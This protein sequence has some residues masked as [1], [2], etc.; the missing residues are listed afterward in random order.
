MADLDAAPLIVLDAT[1]P[2]SEEALD[3]AVRAAAS[4]C[5]HLAHAGRVLAAAAGRPA[6]DRDRP[7]PRRPG[8]RCT[9]GSRSS[10][11][12]ARR[13][14]A[15]SCRGPARCCGSPAPTSTARPRTLQRLPAGARYRRLA[16]A[17]AARPRRVHG[18]RLHRPAV[19]RAGRAAGGRAAA[20]RA[21]PPAPRRSRVRAP[22]P[23]RPPRRGPRA[24]ARTSP[25]PALAARSPLRLLAFAALALFGAAHWR[26][27]VAGIA[28]AGGCCSSSRSARA[29]AAA[30]AVPRRRSTRAR[31][32]RGPP[33]RARRHGRLTRW[34]RWSPPGLALRLLLPGALGRAG[35]TGSTAASP[36]RRS[37][38]GPTPARTS[39]SRSRS[40][41]ACRCS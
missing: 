27:L 18:R 19:D 26:S 41:S 28:D 8:R 37:S 29:G 22:A 6:A 20:E 30:L 38:S 32:W 2:A 13:R 3:M 40:C 7:R 36:A 35:S 10:R 4:L 33:G 16:D 34:R 17:A 5:V 31:R 23:R 24:A 39:G 9:R 1:A 15:R 14:A 12:V 25:S 11:P 21:A